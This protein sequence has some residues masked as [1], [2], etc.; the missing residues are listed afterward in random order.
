MTPISPNLFHNFS[1]YQKT[2]REA[3]PRP[4]WKSS[5][6]EIRNLISNPNPFPYHLILKWCPSTMDARRRESI[7]IIM[8]RHFWWSCK[9]KY[10]REKSFFATLYQAVSQRNRLW[11]ISYKTPIYDKVSWNEQDGGRDRDMHRKNSLPDT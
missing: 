6:F 11:R 7:S 8:S 3:N 9:Q 5:L 4:S 1:F 2:L 10:A